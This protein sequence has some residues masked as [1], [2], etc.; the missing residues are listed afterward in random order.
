MIPPASPGLLGPI[1]R[2]CRSRSASNKET[3]REEL[4]LQQLEGVRPL[5]AEEAGQAPQYAERFDGPR[6]LGRP[7]VL[8]LPSE[9]IEQPRYL[10]LGGGVVATDEHGRLD[11][12]EVGVDHEGTADRRKDFDEA[13]R[14]R[15]FLEAF[16]Q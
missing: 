14:R 9:L 10:G 16:H 12:A 2:G 15:F 4:L 8:R 7:H 3:V 11:A 13:R 6:S 5:I 1:L